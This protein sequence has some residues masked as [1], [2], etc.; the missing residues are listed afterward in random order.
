MAAEK[1]IQKPG[2]SDNIFGHSQI[3]LH[4]ERNASCVGN[5]D[6][7]HYYTF[8]DFDNFTAPVLTDNGRGSVCDAE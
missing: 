8:E 7:H 4:N 3:D 5:L 1:I 2:N 6:R